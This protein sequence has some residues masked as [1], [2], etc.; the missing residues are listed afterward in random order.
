M[1]FTSF[2]S[3]YLLARSYDCDP[4]RTLTLVRYCELKCRLY[5]NFTS[6][7]SKYPYSVPEFQLGSHRAWIHHPVCSF[8]DF[9][10]LSRP[11]H[12]WRTRNSYLAQCPPVWC[13]LKIRCNPE[14]MCPVGV[15]YQGYLI[16][17]V[18]LPVRDNLDH[19]VRWCV[20]G[21]S[22]INLLFCPFIIRNSFGGNAL[23]WCRCPL[24]S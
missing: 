8:S 1:P 19:L 15:P 22:T 20:L 16:A 6:F 3:C 7:S 4:T 21:F 2:L 5:L 14:V 12:F 18:L 23:R 13:F 9:P 17:S 24:S 10:G 11:W